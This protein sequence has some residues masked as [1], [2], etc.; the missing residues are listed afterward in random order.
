MNEDEQFR[1]DIETRLEA[2]EDG[3]KQASIGVVCSHLQSQLTEPNRRVRG[4]Q[5]LFR[6]IRASFDGL[7]GGYGVQFVPSVI[8]VVDI[9][10]GD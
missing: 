7:H 6:K 9:G 3:M 1:K 10:T 8:R 2:V 5:S 4:C